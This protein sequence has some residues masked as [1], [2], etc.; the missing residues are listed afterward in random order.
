MYQKFKLF[1]TFLLSNG[2]LFAVAALIYVI[3]KMV[4]G[5][6]ITP[7]TITLYDVAITLVIH[8]MITFTFVN[9][10]ETQN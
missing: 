4:M 7:T 1:V 10:D 8:S 2:F 3:L 6:H 5:L 9:E